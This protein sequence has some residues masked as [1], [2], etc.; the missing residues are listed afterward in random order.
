M[1][2]KKNK[3]FSLVTSINKNKELN[4]PINIRA[5]DSY[6]GLNKESPL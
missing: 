3:A 1:N 6:I 5:I 2:M 4:D